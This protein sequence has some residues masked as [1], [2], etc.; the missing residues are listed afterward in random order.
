MYVR[1][2]SATINFIII[3]KAF[4]SLHVLYSVYYIDTWKQRKK[5]F[6]HMKWKVRDGFLSTVLTKWKKHSLL[7]IWT[8]KWN[9]V[10]HKD[11]QLLSMND[12]FPSEKTTLFC[13][14]L[15]IS[16]VSIFPVSSLQD[17]HSSILSTLCYLIFKINY[18]HLW[19]SQTQILI[20]TLFLIFSV[21]F[22]I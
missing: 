16:D 2:T 8:G 13:K 14:N 11:G 7:H 10:S 5:I 9:N 22:Q 6:F 4:R 21:S 18:C 19:L 17:V 20:N 3:L 1:T 15:K 12:F